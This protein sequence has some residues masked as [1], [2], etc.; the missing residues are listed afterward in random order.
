[1]LGTSYRRK[2]DRFHITADRLHGGSDQPP[3]EGFK[4]SLAAIELRQAQP[5]KGGGQV[6]PGTLIAGRPAG[7]ARQ[8]GQRISGIR[9]RRSGCWRCGRRDWWAR[10]QVPG[11][12][13]KRR[14]DS[15]LGKNHPGKWL[16]E[17]VGHG[18]NLVGQL[19]LEN[20]GC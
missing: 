19:R 9:A 15:A 8:Y 4:C 3:L 18:A 7:C 16:T 5:P 20:P 11:H 17:Q 14:D 1:M 10:D 6:E 13:H 12:E 2:H